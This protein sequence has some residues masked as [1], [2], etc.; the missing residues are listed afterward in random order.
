MQLPLP[1]VALLYIYGMVDYNWASGL[2]AF[3]TV[4]EAHPVCGTVHG[5]RDGQAS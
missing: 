1:I 3:G 2:S 4:D 5:G